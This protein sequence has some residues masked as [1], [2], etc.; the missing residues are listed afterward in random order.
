MRVLIVSQHF[1]PESFPIN[2]LALG[3]RE[4]GHIVT[5]FTAIPNYPSSRFFP[6][7][8]Y[9]RKLREN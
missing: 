2:G 8:G 7:Y 6:G 4:R 3:L 5:V 1:W 9:F